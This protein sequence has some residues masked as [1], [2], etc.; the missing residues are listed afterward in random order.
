MLDT[1]EQTVVNVSQ[2]KTLQLKYLKIEMD[3]TPFRKA[4]DVFQEIPEK[5][6][7]NTIQSNCLV[8]VAGAFSLLGRS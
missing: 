3:S 2:L 8:L 7:V 4:T 1:R 5:E 6:V